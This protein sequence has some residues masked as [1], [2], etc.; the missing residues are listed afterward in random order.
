M[1]PEAREIFRQ[2]ILSIANNASPVGVTARIFEVY[3]R[4]LGITH[5]RQELEAQ[6]AYLVDKGLLKITDKA[7]SPE[8]RVWTVTSQGTDYLAS[9]GLA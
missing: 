3:L 4:P 2:E 8:L 1:T 7:I 5:T 6:I 9:N